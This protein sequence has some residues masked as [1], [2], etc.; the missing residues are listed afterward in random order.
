MMID[1]ESCTLKDLACSDCVVSVMISITS[2]G[3]VTPAS[4]K[5]IATLADLG[6]VPPL[7]FHA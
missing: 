2:K 6:V 4:V 1:C 7:R 3:D 5:A